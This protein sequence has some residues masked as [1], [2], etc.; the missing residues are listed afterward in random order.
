[1]SNCGGDIRWLLRLQL[2]IRKAKVPTCA[3]AL[4]EPLIPEN[5]HLTSW[6]VCGVC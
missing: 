6:Q 2:L 4:R 5:L 3:E 1:L